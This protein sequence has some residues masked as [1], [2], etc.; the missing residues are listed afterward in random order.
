MT[1]RKPDAAKSI[2]VGESSSVA[3]GLVVTV[4]FLFCERIMRD[5][6]AYRGGYRV[7]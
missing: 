1:V 2:K 4:R 6:T 7:R 5:V 3:E